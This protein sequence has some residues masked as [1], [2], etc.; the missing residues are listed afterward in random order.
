MIKFKWLEWLVI[1]WL[2]FFLSVVFLHLHPVGRWL[3]SQNA[4]AWVQAVGVILGLLIAVLVP[5]LQHQQAVKMESSAAEKRASHL[6]SIAQ[7]IG[8]GAEHAVTLYCREVAT[9]DP[10]TPFKAG[11]SLLEQTSRQIER[12]NVQLLQESSLTD[13]AQRLNLI[14]TPVSFCL[15]TSKRWSSGGQSPTDSELANLMKRV[16]QVRVNR[17]SLND[18]VVKHLKVGSA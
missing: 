14:W 6:A 13:V 5:A 8:R 7:E 18:A 15:D 9:W 1:G 2:V 12:L 16:A 17:S 4:A 3:E 11:T 10:N